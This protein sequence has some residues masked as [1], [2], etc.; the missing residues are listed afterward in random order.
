MRNTLGGALP[1]QCVFRE[2]LPMAVSGI[3]L[4]KKQVKQVN[5]CKK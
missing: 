3:E 2:I 5:V 4:K 1:A